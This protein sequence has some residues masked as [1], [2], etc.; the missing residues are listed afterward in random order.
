MTKASDWEAEKKRLKIQRR[1]WSIVG[2]EEHINVPKLEDAIRKEF[3]TNDA[4]FV[5]SQIR[6]MQSEAKISVQNKVKVWIKQPN[7]NPSAH[8]RSLRKVH[9]DWKE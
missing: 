5:E 8:A 3:K 4:R 2:S 9:A 6:L 1:F 7:T